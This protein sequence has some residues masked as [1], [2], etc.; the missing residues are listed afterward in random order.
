MSKAPLTA[1][2]LQENG[3]IAAVGAADG[4]TSVL[5]LSNSL[6]EM[7]PN[8]KY[9]VSSVRRDLHLLF[10]VSRVCQEDDVYMRTTGCPA[11]V[12]PALI[13]WLKQLLPQQNILVCRSMQHSNSGNDLMWKSS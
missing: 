4:S 10:A 2:R 6:A 1:L 5:R 9:A 11:W 8:E 3:R 12:S 13:G 7:Q